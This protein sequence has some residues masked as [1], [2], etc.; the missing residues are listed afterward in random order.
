[1]KI[2]CLIYFL[3]I[4]YTLENITT[5]SFYSDK[6]HGKNTASGEKF[7]MN[8]LTAAHK[9]LPFN[10]LVEITNLNNNQSVIVRIND[11][12]PFI[13]GRK[14]DLSKA[15]FKQICPLRYGKIKVKYKII[16]NEFN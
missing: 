4:S 16:T 10:T 12:G 15:A 6:H 7:D 8:K 2:I 14:F 5:V 11:R 1:M 9:T 3:C 13:K